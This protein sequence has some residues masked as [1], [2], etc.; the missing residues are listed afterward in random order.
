MKFKVYN[1]KIR[2]EN[3]FD[4]TKPT[5]AQNAHHRLG[6]ILHQEKPLTQAQPPVLGVPRRMN[7]GSFPT[8]VNEF[9]G[10]LPV[11]PF[12]FDHDTLLLTVTTL[13]LNVLCVGD[14]TTTFIPY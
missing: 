13:F 9:E 3:R 11:K 12:A 1:E 2:N 4:Q 5:I 10:F 7:L 6:N 14:K 8:R